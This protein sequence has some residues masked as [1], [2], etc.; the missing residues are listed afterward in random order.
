MVESIQNKS[1]MGML[2][3]GC[4]ASLDP[5]QSDFASFEQG[6]LRRLSI[7]TE[8]AEN[9]PRELRLGQLKIR[10]DMYK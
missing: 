6:S 10:S 7:K 5:G 8:Q 3:V 1:S 2:W 4:V 9:L